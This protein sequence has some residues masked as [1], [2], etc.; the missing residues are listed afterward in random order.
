[1]YSMSSFLG[2]KLYLRQIRGNQEIAPMAK[3]ESY[4]FNYQES[5]RMNPPKV[6]LPGDEII[7]ECDYNSMDRDNVTFVR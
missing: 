6:I 2:R 3:D 1:M 5:Q 7:M 4:D